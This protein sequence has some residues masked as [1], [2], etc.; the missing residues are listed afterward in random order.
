MKIKSIVIVLMLVLVLMGSAFSQDRQPQFE[1]FGGI[2]IPLAPDMF[3]DYYK[4]GISPHVQYVIFPTPRLGISF[5]AAYE[6]FSFDGD[7]FA[8]DFDPLVEDLFYIIYGYPIDMRNSKYEGSANNV[9]LAVGIRPYITPPEAST[10]LF[11]YGMATYNMLKNK[12]DMK[13]TDIY[14]PSTSTLLGSI[15]EDL[16]LF[17]ESESKFGVG[18]G[19][20]IEIPAGDSFNIILQ[21]VF[22]FIF[23]EDDNTNFVGIT[24]GLV[25]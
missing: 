7:K 12:A 9:E 23:T 21:G 25:F 22:R 18:V 19:A 5:G 17:D 4:I 1:A 20:G 2:A 15:D 13:S 14:D 3:K 10:Q 11:V 6:R 16:E 8:E 24:A